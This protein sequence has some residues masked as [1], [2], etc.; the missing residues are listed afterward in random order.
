[1]TNPEIIP[2][3]K[4]AGQE[5]K[6]PQEIRQHQIEA[7]DVGPPPREDVSK[8]K[9]DPWW[10]TRFWSIQSARDLNHPVWWPVAA[11]FYVGAAS[12]WAMPFLGVFVLYKYGFR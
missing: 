10:R 11:L 2:L 3:I 9:H 6:G 4:P 8:F 12:L 7:K 5:Q 1:M